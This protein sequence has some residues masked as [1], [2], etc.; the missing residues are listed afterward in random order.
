MQ[1]AEKGRIPVDEE[2]MVKGHGQRWKRVLV[3]MRHQIRDFVVV[4]ARRDPLVVFL[5]LCDWYMQ[6]GMYV[7]ERVRYGGVQVHVLDVS[8]NPPP[9]HIPIRLTIP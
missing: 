1:A 3:R 2:E 5:K 8:P 6:E 4:V 9:N 7:C